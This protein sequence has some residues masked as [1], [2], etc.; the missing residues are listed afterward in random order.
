MILA[1]VTAI[2]E[3]FYN[4]NLEYFKACPTL[5]LCGK[6]IKTATGSK[7]TRLKLQVMIPTKINNLT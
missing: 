4:E 6:F 5:P 7:S 3:K 1:F 2:S